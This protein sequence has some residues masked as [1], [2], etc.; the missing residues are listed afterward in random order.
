MRPRERG[1]EKEPVHIL[2]RL[3]MAFLLQS[4]TL[5]CFFLRQFVCIFIVHYYRCTYGCG[6]DVAQEMGFK[7]HSMTFPM[8][9]SQ[10]H[11]RICATIFELIPRD[12]SAIST[13]YIDAIHHHVVPF[14]Y[15]AA[16]RS[17][18]R[19]HAQSHM[20]GLEAISFEFW[21]TRMDTRKK[22]GARAHSY[23][24]LNVG[25][26]WRRLRHREINWWNNAS[27]CVVHW[28]T[29]LHGLN[30]FGWYINSLQYYHLH[31]N[32]LTLTH[33]RWSH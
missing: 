17:L 18:F 23:M 20:I 9:E 5:K 11:R 3:F 12:A 21:A 27:R 15:Y 33:S 28:H 29:V 2:I 24:N 1:R 26:W 19:P 10:P 14:A 6:R 25:K 4:L 30:R 7:V 8:H 16:G 22:C 32:A 31:T 13:Y